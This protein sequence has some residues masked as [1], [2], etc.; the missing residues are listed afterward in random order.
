MVRFA[1]TLG[2]VLIEHLAKRVLVFEA[3][4]L[5]V[6]APLAQGDGWNQ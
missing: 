5:A 4:G 3:A 2:V 1:S 6:V